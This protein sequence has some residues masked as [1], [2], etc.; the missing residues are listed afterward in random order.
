MTK[1][2]HASPPT[3]LRLPD[4]RGKVAL[5]T[6]AS[7]GIGLATVEALL[8]NGATCFGL[9]RN[10]GPIKSDAFHAVACNLSSP[11]EI[12]RALADVRAKTRHLDYIVNVAGIDPKHTLAE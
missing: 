11:T 6:G 9:A 2:L 10:A 12:A 8:A 5:V 4:L 7:A 3:D 1:E